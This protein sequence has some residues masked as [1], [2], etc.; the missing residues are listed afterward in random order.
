MALPRPEHLQ[1]PGLT[2]PTL[3]CEPVFCQALCVG[4]HCGSGTNPWARETRGASGTPAD[5][6]PH[7]LAR[8]LVDLYS[9]RY[10]LTVPYE[11][12]KRRRRWVPWARGSL[13]HSQPRAVGSAVTPP[14]SQKPRTPGLDTAHTHP[15]PDRLNG[16]KNVE[17]GGPTAFA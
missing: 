9:Q 8:P 6:V 16:G 3:L 14:L 5:P 2:G 10:F 1:N 17:V 15:P 7:S 11:E 4:L 12:C 13:G